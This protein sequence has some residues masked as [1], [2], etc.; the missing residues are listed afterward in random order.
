MRARAKNPE[1][2]YSTADDFALDLAQLLGQQKEELVDQEM[3]EVAVLLDQGEVYKAQGSLLRVLKIDQQHTRATR[4]LREVQ[5]RIQRDE[6][7][8]QVRGLRGRAEEAL[9]DEQFD[10][11]LE[12]MDRA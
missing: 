8:K 12:H 7:G 6:L 5:Q 3:E 9:A 1:E 4:L 2:Q 10:W 11:A